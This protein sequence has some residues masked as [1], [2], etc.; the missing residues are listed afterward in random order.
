MPSK[1]W[2][3][4]L[5]VEDNRNDADLML[6]AFEK[7]NLLNRV[8]VIEDGNEALEFIF[9]NGHNLKIIILDLNLPGK[10]GFDI[11][12][13]I[14]LNQKTK[15]IPV[16]I[17]TMS[18][19]DKNVTKGYNLGANSYIVKPVDFVKFAEVISALGFYWVFL[20]IPPKP[21]HSL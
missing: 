3:E 1:K 13:E 5:L 17:L 4:I 8:Y 12:K 15:T 10:N 11:L 7:Y 21:Y 14:K 9:K 2:A 18:R 6:K 16:V 19:E 20:N